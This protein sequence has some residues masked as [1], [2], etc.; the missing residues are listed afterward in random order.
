MFKQMGKNAL[1]SVVSTALP[2]L[3]NIAIG[4]QKRGASNLT[5]AGGQIAVAPIANPITPVLGVVVVLSIVGGII[6]AVTRKKKG[7]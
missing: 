3:T 4:G 6:F 5:Q 2:A 7:R 1:S